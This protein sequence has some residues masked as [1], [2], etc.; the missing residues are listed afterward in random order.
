MCP[1]RFQ[2]G[3]SEDGWRLSSKPFGLVGKEAL[4]PFPCPPAFSTSPHHSKARAPQQLQDE[5]SDIL[6]RAAG[7]K[8]YRQLTEVEIFWAVRW[9]WASRKPVQTMRTRYHWWRAAV[10]GRASG[11]RWN[12][13]PS[14]LPPGR[15]VMTD[16][17]RRHRSPGGGQGPPDMSLQKGTGSFL[18]TCYVP[19]SPLDQNH[20]RTVLRI[21]LVH[22]SCVPPR[23]VPGSSCEK[24]ARGQPPSWVPSCVSPKLS[25]SYTPLSLRIHSLI[26]GTQTQHTGRPAGCELS[27]LP[28]VIW[29]SFY[30]P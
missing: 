24:W 27:C 2:C 22:H 20:L 6:N 21:L 14:V 19:A 23:P 11:Q 3:N 26:L 15:A 10:E 17:P 8:Y 13:S 28:S 9:G 1:Q 25:Y 5:N 29:R 18:C 30:H 16:V 7:C 4:R 12:D